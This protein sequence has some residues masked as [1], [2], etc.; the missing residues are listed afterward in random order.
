[1]SGD[2]SELLNEPPALPYPNSRMRIP[3]SL[4]VHQL[5]WLRRLRPISLLRSHHEAFLLQAACSVPK[6]NETLKVGQVLT[7]A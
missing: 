6:L 5:F 7:V 3:R 4:T 2:N 1:M